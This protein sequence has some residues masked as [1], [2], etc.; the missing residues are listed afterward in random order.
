[1]GVLIALRVSKI[2]FWW[3]PIL[4]PFFEQLLLGV[5]LN[6]DKV[7]L[8][9]SIMSYYAKDVRAFQ[10]IP[11]NN[12][13]T[14]MKTFLDNPNKYYGKFIIIFVQEEFQQ[15]NLTTMQLRLGNE[16]WN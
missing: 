13:R 11:G 15:S 8:F 7:D 5:D 10:R 14:K 1:M 16:L 9:E 4:T 12:T 3:H 6:Q 2:V